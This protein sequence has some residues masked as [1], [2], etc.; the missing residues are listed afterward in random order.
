MAGKHT[1]SLSAG[2]CVRGANIQR[3]R[4]EKKNYPKPVNQ[5]L[6]DG[7]DGLFSPIF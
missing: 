2:L 5:V 6:K 1:Q 7:Y 3:D 4:V